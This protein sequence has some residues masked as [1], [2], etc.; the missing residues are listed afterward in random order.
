MAAF[1][2]RWIDACGIGFAIIMYVGSERAQCVRW[3]PFEAQ[4]EWLSVIPFRVE[5]RRRIEG[6]PCV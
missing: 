5:H 3:K 4:P 6:V 2:A 1:L